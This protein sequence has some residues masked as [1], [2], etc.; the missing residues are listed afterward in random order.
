MYIL[1]SARIGKSVP[2]VEGLCWAM[3]VGAIMLAP[4]G[5]VSAGVTLL[6]LRLLAIVLV[7]IAAAGTSKFR[8]IEKS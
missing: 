4:V 7:S 5:I 3:L 8:A 6:N 2:G 1:L